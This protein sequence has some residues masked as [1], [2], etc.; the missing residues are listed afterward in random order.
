M[1]HNGTI[2]P[3]GKFQALG[4]LRYQKKDSLQS[5]VRQ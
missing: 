1:M 5:L 2:E 3:S 4:Q